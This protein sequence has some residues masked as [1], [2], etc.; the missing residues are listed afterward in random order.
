MDLQCI[1]AVRSYLLDLQERIISAI[2]GFEEG[3]VFARDA[4]QRDAFSGGKTCVLEGGTVIEK[5]GVNFSEV[6]GDAL[7]P[8]A[9]AARPQL[10]G[11]PF[12]VMGVSLVMH[13]RNPHVPTS[14]MNVRF[15]ST[16]EG[17]PI[18]WFGGGFD[19]TPYYPYEEDVIHWHTQAKAACDPF[20]AD[21]YGKYKAQCDRYFHLPHRGE[22][23][24]VG[25]LFFDDFNSGDDFATAFAFT[26]SVADHFIPAYLPIVERRMTTPHTEAERDFQLYRR[27]RYVEFN[28]VHDRGTLFGLQSGGRTE[29]IL[30]SL[31][32]HAQWR[33][34]WNPQPG[35]REAVL[36]ERYLKPQDWLGL[37][38]SSS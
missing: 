7:P 33:Y 12:R 11:M 28:L 22:T 36:Y 20:G 9:T 24:G 5:G 34:N 23:R 3:A 18:W 19:L 6:S 31:P 29:S 4:W 13:P 1:E 8:S 37:C 10:A 2:E 15:F 25:G 26:R 27:G 30:M 21:L 32:P 14:H 38:H 35:S 16:G 17:S